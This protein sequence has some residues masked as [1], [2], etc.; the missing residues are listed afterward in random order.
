MANRC[1]LLPEG[2]SI[3]FRLITHFRLTKKMLWSYVLY[4][5]CLNI[6]INCFSDIRGTFFAFFELVRQFNLLQ[7]LTLPLISCFSLNGSPNRASRNPENSDD[8]VRQ[9]R[10]NEAD[11]IL[12]TWFSSRQGDKK[13][14]YMSYGDI[15]GYGFKPNARGILH[16]DAEQSWK[17]SFR[18]GS[19][20]KVEEKRKLRF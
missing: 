13:N 12:W 3:L 17:D 8:H 2:H 1:I 9:E 10:L 19:F 15:V 16:T 6:L 5:K 4:F 11:F 20:V 18:T 7:S 14:G